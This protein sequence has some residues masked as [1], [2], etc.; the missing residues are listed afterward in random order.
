[1]YIPFGKLF[2]IFQRPGNLGVAYYKRANDE[3]PAAVCRRCGDGVRQRRSRSPTSRPCCPRSASTTRTADGGS[4]Q[5]TCPRCRRAQVDAGPVGTRRGLRLM[6]RPPVTE[7]ELIARY[8][9][10]LNEAPPGGWDAG[11]EVDRVVDTHCCFCGQQCGIKL[12]VRDNAVVGFEPWY[13][14]PFNEG[15][16]CPKGVKRYLQG[17]HPDRLLHPMERDPS[18]PGGFRPITLGRRPRPRRRR[19]PPHPGGVRRRRVRHALGRLADER[20]ELPH[21]Q[22]RPAR[23]AHREPRLQRPLLHGVGRRRQQEGARRRPQRRTRGATSRSP[24]SCGSPARTSPRRS[25]S[26]RATSGGPATAAP[27]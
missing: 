5:D 6:A 7:E 26:R 17:S 23:A 13:E 24:T 11:V 4:Y 19:D 18:A 15:K 22:V 16:L 9:P 1:M 10:H 21:R 12:K 20:E 3:G 14:F 8:G 2:H 27:G 25:R